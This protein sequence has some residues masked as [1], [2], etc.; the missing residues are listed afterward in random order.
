MSHAS[1]ISSVFYEYYENLDE[2]QIRLI[3]DQEIIQCVVSNKLVKNSIP[4][5]TTQKPKLWDYADNID[6]IVF[7]TTL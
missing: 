7:L 3:A 6:T 2:V 4:F 1:P 5:G